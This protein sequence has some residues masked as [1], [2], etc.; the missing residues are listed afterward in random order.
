MINLVYI[1]LYLIPGII[2]G[3]YGSL[4]LKKGSSK[5]TFNLKKWKN[6]LEVIFGLVLFGSSTIFYLL[7]LPYGEL[8]VVYPLSSLSYIFISIVSM[9]YLD[10]KMTKLKWT[11]IVLIMIGSFLVVR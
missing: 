6:N 10:E 8:S 4:F 2:L 1:L 9:W 11:G 5:L 7:A 3:G